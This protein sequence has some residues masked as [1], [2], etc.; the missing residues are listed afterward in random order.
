MEALLSSPGPEQSETLINSLKYGLD[1]QGNYIQ[2]RRASTT[3]SNVNSASPQ[4]VKQITINCGSSS[5]WLDPQSVLLSFLITNGDNANEL[6]PATTG[7]HCLFDRLTLKM[8]STVVEDIQDFNKITQMLTRLSVPADKHKDQAQLGFG[9]DATNEH[10][11]RKIAASGSKRV[12]MKFDVS[13]L[14]SQHRMLPLFSLGGQGFSIQLN[15]APAVQAVI[16]SDSGTTYS[17]TYTLSDIRLLADM[18]SL[19]SELQE[20]YNSALLNGTSLK[21][22][23]KSWESLVNYLA[24]DSSGS[25]DVAIS[26]SYTRLATLLCQFNQSEDANYAG[27]AKWV[28]SGY[29]PTAKSENI[30]Y[31]LALGSRRIPD[32]DV[33]GT[34]ESWFRLQNAVGNY[35]SLAHATSITEDEYRSTQYSLAVDCEKVPSLM[36]SGENLSGGQTIFLKCKGFGSSSIDVP[37]RAFI[38]MHFEKVISIMDTVVEC[39]S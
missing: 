6:W 10:D 24:A 7:C 2:V 38:C 33:R 14:L 25:F 1:P 18:I 36:A 9:S 20:S 11:A 13:G 8:G 30:E 39:Y 12:Y 35:H 37:R 21:I 26:K 5:E 27:K 31:H 15:L 29:F 3:F 19:D 4:S 32:N 22:C 28:N 17:T 34:S 23:C 16:V